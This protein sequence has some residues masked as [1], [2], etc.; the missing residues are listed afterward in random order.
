MPT[1]ITV[2]SN[3][4]FT[5]TALSAPQDGYTIAIAQATPSPTATPVPT[6]TPSPTLTAGP[7]PSPSATP[8]GTPFPTPSDTPVPTASPTG[9]PVPTASTT[10]V[11]TA[12]VTPVPTSTPAPSA[13]ATPVPTASATPVPTSTPAPSASATP[14]PPTP[15]PTP[16]T[17][18]ISPTT[19]PNPTVGVAY[20][21]TVT[22]S[23]G[24]SPYTYSVASGS[25]P[26]GLSLNSSTGVISGTPTASGSVSFT[27]SASDSASPT[28][29]GNRPYTVNVQAGG[30]A[31]P[32]TG[33]NCCDTFCGAGSI[34]SVSWPAYGSANKYAIT[35][36]NTSD[37][38]WFNITTPSSRTIFMTTTGTVILISDDSDIG[39]GDPPC[40]ALGAAAS[41]TQAQ[42]A[43]GVTLPVNQTG[44]FAIVGAFGVTGTFDIWVV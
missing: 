31:T 37:Q 11:P 26:A 14:V 12:S 10:P 8:A 17:L 1:C 25:L 21:E 44:N 2:N 40:S 20:S 13:S 29:T 9:T 18:T 43:A 32:I 15:S 35:I 23:L 7:T 42:W 39:I 41:K 22:A 16:V 19:L 36:A 34:P 4:D 33:G 6:P 38:Q 28:G 5:V 30:G 24:T 3:V 27:I